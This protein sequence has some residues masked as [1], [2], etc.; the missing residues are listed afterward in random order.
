MPADS[1]RDPRTALVHDKYFS[2]RP[3]PLE[4]WIWRQGLPQAAERV[5]W[6]HWEEGMRAGDWC[7]RIPL[8]RVALECCIDPSTVTR[9]YQLLKRFGLI[10]REDPG[11]DPD[12]PFQQAT[13]V[14]EIRLPRELLTELGRAPNRPPRAA[15]T[16][17]TAAAPAA[18]TAAPATPAPPVESGSSPTPTLKYRDYQRLLAR[19]SPAEKAAFERA[20]RDRTGAM[21]F[22]AD[23]RLTAEE[24]R[25]LLRQLQ[26]M[27]QPAA[28]AATSSA[29]GTAPVTRAASGY[30]GPR[31]LSPLDTA[32]LR[33][34]LGE[35]VPSAVL[36][37]TLRQVLWSV[38][39]GAL[40]RFEPLKAVNI[41]LKKIREGAWTRPNRMPPQWR[42]A[43]P[44]AIA[45]RPETCSAA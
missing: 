9:A 5:F 15:A 10:R 7:S 24:Q 8:K 35:T 37:E 40:R 14:T 39:E 21:T 36:T 23:T 30:A 25:Y 11:R 19:L 38:E 33:K 31:R 26:L 20:W 32:R 1:A 3:K 43:G 34:R 41:A 28:G 45:A 29:R 4:R 44:E 42:V 6:M 18:P 17:A 13:A 27:M 16:P 2:L 22:A 12:N